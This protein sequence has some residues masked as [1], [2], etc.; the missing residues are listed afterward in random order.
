MPEKDFLTLLLVLLGLAHLWLQLYNRVLLNIPDGKLKEPTHLFSFIVIIILPTS[1]LLLFRN[2]PAID[3]ALSWAPNS[4]GSMLYFSSFA[5]IWI[6]MLWRFGLV[7][8]DLAF[9]PTSHRVLADEK[10]NVAV[11]KPKSP[12]PEAFA[13]LDSTFD[14]EFRDLELQIRYLPT[15]FDGISLLMV[16]D[17]HYETHPDWVRW[18]NELQSFCNNLNPDLVIFTGDFINH[19]DDLDAA[20][21]YHAGFEGKIGKIG[22][23]GNHDYWTRPKKIRTLCKRTGIQ[24][25]SQEPLILKRNDRRLIFSGTDAPW[26]GRGVDSNSLCQRDATDCLIYLSHTP[27]NAPLAAQ[28]D[29]YLILSGHTHGGQLRL[30]VLGPIV[31]PSRYGRQFSDGLFD[32]NESSVLVVSRGVGCSRLGSVPTG[33]IRLA[34]RP[35]VLRITLRA[36]FADIALRA[37]ALKPVLATPTTAVSKISY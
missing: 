15:E 20:M 17:I 1:Y 7:V 11:R 23:L 22:V 25:V 16:S 30:P 3:Q 9:P 18:Y 33:G 34:C 8:A 31:V 37:K 36:P 12:L 24:L 13:S 6:L 27:D 26:N 4:W 32:L 2:H 35:E 5:L 29:A 21:E 28:N 10:T 19:E 14:L